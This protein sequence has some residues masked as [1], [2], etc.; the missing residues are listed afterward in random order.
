MNTRAKLPLIPP[1]FWPSDRDRRS[2]KF[3]GAHGSP[4]SWIAR[5]RFHWVAIIAY[6]QC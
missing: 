4:S 2:R 3:E 1:L 6:N 5:V